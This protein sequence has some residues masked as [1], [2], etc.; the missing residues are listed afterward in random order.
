MIKSHYSRSICFST[1]Q[2]LFLRGLMRC[3]TSATYE[4]MC[5]VFNGF[6]H[7]LKEVKLATIKLLQIKY[8]LIVMNIIKKA[9]QLKNEFINLNNLY[10]Y[11]IDF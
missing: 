2:F 5:D 8:N 1:S 3:F 4:S 6:Y 9:T 11:H 10:L 7:C